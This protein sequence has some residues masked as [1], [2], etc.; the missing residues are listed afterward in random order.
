MTTLVARINKRSVIR[1][2]KVGFNRRVNALLSEMA[3]RGKEIVQTSF[4]DSPPN[5]ERV[6]KSPRTKQLRNPSFPGNPPRIDSRELFRS[7]K[8]KKVNNKRWEVLADHTKAATL[9]FGSPSGKPPAARPFMSPMVD[10][11]REEAPSFAKK[12]IS[13]PELRKV[14]PRLR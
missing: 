5:L 13:E 6:Y 12:V 1:Q 3:K 8:A 14:I 2:A 7:I 9:E 4:E 11:L 10:R